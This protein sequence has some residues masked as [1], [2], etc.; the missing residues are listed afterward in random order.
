MR[1]LRMRCRACDE[2]VVSA[3]EISLFASGP[4]R[5]DY[6][7]RCPLCLS[8]VKRDCDDAKARLL[9]LDGAREEPSHPA[10]SGPEERF[11][12]GPGHVDELRRLLDRPDWFDLLQDAGAA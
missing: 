8:V 10:G 12:F 7:F 9:L 5:W 4:N 3:N 6:A 1:K 2:V 11:A